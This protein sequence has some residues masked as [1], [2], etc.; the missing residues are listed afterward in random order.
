MEAVGTVLACSISSITIL[1]GHVIVLI[2]SCSGGC[3][4]PPSL[5]SGLLVPVLNTDGSVLGMD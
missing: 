5:S 3:A 4:V 2:W 1:A